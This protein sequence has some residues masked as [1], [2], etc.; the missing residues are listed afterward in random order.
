MNL[1]ILNLETEKIWGFARRG[2]KLFNYG[3]WK[4]RVFNVFVR[5]KVRCYVCVESII[6]SLLQESNWRYNSDP[7]FQDLI[8]KAKFPTPALIS[9]G[10][11]FQFLIDFAVIK[12]FALELKLSVRL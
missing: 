12:I 5:L 2:S 9:K 1:R 4:K 3:R 7:H 10:L 11:P 6:T 8:K